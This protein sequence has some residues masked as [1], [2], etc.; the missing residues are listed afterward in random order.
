MYVFSRITTGYKK[1]L[2]GLAC[3]DAVEHRQFDDFAVMACADGHGD[4]KCKYAAKGAELA[5]WTICKILQEKRS[6]ADGV[7]DF[8]RGLNDGRESI[9]K[10]F[11][12]AWVGAV[13]DDYKV[14]HAEDAAFQS[15]FKELSRYAKRIYHVRSEEMPVREFRKLAE[16]RHKCEEEIYKIT[17]LYG[18]T[19]NAAVITDKFVF[20]I[21]IGDGDV[22]AVNGK[23]AEWLLPAYAQFTD[24]PASLCG[25]FGIMP[26]NFKTNYV[27]VTKGRRLT[28]CYFRPETVTISTDGLRNAFLSDEAFAEKLV[29]IADA[30]RKGEGQAFVR[31]GKKWISERSE[32]GVT[33]DDIAFAMWTKYPLRAKKAESR[34]GA[35]KGKSATAKSRKSEVR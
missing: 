23:R 17:L 21:G 18:T 10:S 25:N 34:K 12:C 29:E 1:F 33:Q 6:E 24:S 7:E 14:N 8:G 9:I 35:E 4:R 27:P 2:K 22:V 32:Y 16:Y 31:N 3:E 26:D 11:I 15:V 5:V 28:D 19:V 30:F 20:A 13:L